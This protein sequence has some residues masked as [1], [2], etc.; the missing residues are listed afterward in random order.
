MKRF[1]YSGLVFLAVFA[2]SIV[3]F[4]QFA[5]ASV[6]SCQGG[7]KQV[8]FSLYEPTNSHGAVDNEANAQYKVCYDQIFGQ[9]YTG[10]DS[11]LRT[12]S[13]SNKIVRLTGTTN[14]HAEIPTRTSAEYSTQICYGDLT[15]RVVSGSA[16][17][18]GTNEFL[19]V[20]LSDDGNAHLSA[21]SGTVYT[22]KICCSSAS[23]TPP[24]NCSTSPNPFVQINPFSQ[25]YEQDNVPI[26]AT[27][28][29]LGQ[30]NA[31][32]TQVEFFVDG[33]SIGIVQSGA[34][35]YS[36]VWQRATAGQHTIIATATDSC[37]KTGSDTK[38][39]NIETIPTPT[40]T[41][42]EWYDPN[43]NSKAFQAPLEALV[44][45]TGQTTYSQGTAF[46]IEIFKQGLDNSI[47]T[48]SINSDNSGVIRTSNNNL[49]QL[50][51]NQ[52]GVGDTIKFIVR[53]QDG[54]ENTSNNLRITGAGTPTC[55]NIGPC[56]LF[57]SQ[58]QDACIHA[59]PEGAPPSQ[60]SDDQ[61]LTGP[62]YENR[63]V[64]NNNRCDYNSTRFNVQQQAEGSCIS[65]YENLGDCIDG[66]RRVN[67]T[68][69]YKPGICRTGSCS[70]KETYI[71]CGRSI[72]AL[73][74]FTITQ[75]IIAA[76]LIIIAYVIIF[77]TNIFKHKRR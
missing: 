46:G 33:A 12:C 22:R 15:C 52:A 16:L 28:G 76:I 21:S 67:V 53:H 57:T 71:P 14:A 30:T 25:Y 69:E 18:D 51:N 4:L 32:I 1:V 35:A 7:S 59:C 17:C 41:K 5:S 42:A 54:N 2:A 6:N 70:A 75:L 38:I 56:E 66:K 20:A 24:I 10:P 65:H 77:R 36:T 9:S 13:A 58:G 23:Y 40:I 61:C 73:P 60:A 74:F 48:T 50:L 39:L 45:A 47:Y 27:A 31:R 64:W 29:Y 72:A 26:S 55:T 44:I 34:Q 63:C 19:V 11:T 37:R 43:T 8:I 62:I 3:L 68:A 49:R